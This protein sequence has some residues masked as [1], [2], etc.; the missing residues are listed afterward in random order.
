MDKRYRALR[1]IGTIYKVIGAI[2]AVITILGAIG[3]CI[4]SIAG[5]AAFNSILSQYSNS[6][7]TLSGIFG[8]VLL[9]FIVILYGGLMSVTMYGFGEGIYLL[10]ALEENTRTTASLLQ[11][12]NMP[13]A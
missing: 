2:L 6:A 9:G 13:K 5:G 7:G 3:I 11:Q 1:T 12:Q 4:T 10:I 8:G